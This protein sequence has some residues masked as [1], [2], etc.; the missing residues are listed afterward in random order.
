MNMSYEGFDNSRPADTLAEML[1]YIEFGEDDRLNINI[2][3]VVNGRVLVNGKNANLKVESKE[4]GSSF[5]LYYM[6][7]RK[8][9]YTDYTLIHESKSGHKTPM[10]TLG[11]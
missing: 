7:E 11:L 8:Q 2:P 4:S 6:P 10:P 3:V 1:K 9:N 5:K